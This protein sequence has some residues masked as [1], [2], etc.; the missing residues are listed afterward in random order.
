[1]AL[2]QHDKIPPVAG[3]LFVLGV[4]IFTRS[5]FAIATGDQIE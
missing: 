4:S 2:L 3:K 5:Q 1:L